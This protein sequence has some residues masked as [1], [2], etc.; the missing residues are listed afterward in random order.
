[1]ELSSALY[2]LITMTNEDNVIK[3]LPHLKLKSGECIFSEGEKGDF[4]Y[5]IEEGVVEISTVVNGR[6][7]IL[8][9]LKAGEL[10][11]ELA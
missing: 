9:T 11:G 10:F 8:N 6:Y 7:T 5:I 3:E 2:Q 1:M 4:A